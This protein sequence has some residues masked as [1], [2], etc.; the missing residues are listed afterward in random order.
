MA[1]GGTVSFNFVVSIPKLRRDAVVTDDPGTAP[2]DILHLF[3]TGADFHSPGGP[4]AN[5]VDGTAPLGISPDSTMPRSSRKGIVCE[6]SLQGCVLRTPL[7]LLS[8]LQTS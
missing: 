1:I 7:T 2:Q 8:N 3:G 5:H 4:L 6:V